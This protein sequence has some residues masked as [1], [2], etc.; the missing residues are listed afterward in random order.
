MRLI[1]KFD[2]FRYCVQRVL[3]DDEKKILIFA[4][5]ALWFFFNFHPSQSYYGYT[6]EVLPGE[7]KLLL[8]SDAGCFGGLKRL[9]G[10]QHY[11][12]T[13]VY[14]G[15]TRQNMLSL[16]LPTRTALVLQKLN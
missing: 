11:F 12:T 3:I 1:K 4:R 8:D 13:T 10:G 7:Y 6:V 9:S 14:S 2:L 16:Y 15:K 5:G